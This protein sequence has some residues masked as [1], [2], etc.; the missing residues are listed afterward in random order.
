VHNDPDI[1]PVV[2]PAKVLD[3]I[4]PFVWNL[5]GADRIGLAYCP[6]TSAQ[7][8]MCAVQCRAKGPLEAGYEFERLG[9]A[10]NWACENRCPLVGHRRD[11]MLAYPRTLD[12]L[13]REGFHSNVVIP[14]DVGRFG[15][16]ALF[17]VSRTPSRF[18]GDVLAVSMRLRDVVEP[19]TRTYLA[20]D[21]LLHG[22]V[23][24]DGA[25]PPPTSA[26]TGVMSLDECQRSHIERVLSHTNGIIEGPRGAA[27]LLGLHP[28]TLRNR[29]RKL[30]V[31]RDH[32]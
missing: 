5:L 15:S 19:A 13:K 7:F 12:Y 9:T 23:L 17:M 24:P 25:S 26:I 4:S 27:A 32:N 3:W 2:T 28:S 11:D 8:Q 31:L 14:L 1:T 6:P 20:C 16:A 29:M 22:G 18:D 30:G 21:E 10:G